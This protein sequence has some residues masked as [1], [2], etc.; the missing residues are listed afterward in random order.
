MFQFVDYVKAYWSDLLFVH[1][2]LSNVLK[3]SSKL[4]SLLFSNIHDFNISIS[5]DDEI[6]IVLISTS[7]DRALTLFI[8]GLRDSKMFITSG[9]LTD[10]YVL[11]IAFTL[12]IQGDEV[13]T[14]YILDEICDKLHE[15][16]SNEDREIEVRIKDRLKKLKIGNII[17]YGDK[18]FHFKTIKN[19]INFLKVFVNNYKL[20]DVLDSEVYEIEKIIKSIYNV[21]IKKCESDLNIPKDICAIIRIPSKEEYYKM[22][23]LPSIFV[24]SFY[25]N[26]MNT[27]FEFRTFIYYSNITNTIDLI[28]EIPKTY[29]SYKLLLTKA[30]IQNRDIIKKTIVKLWKTYAITQKIITL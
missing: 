24:F 26:Y 29:E 9:L 21:N 28:I 12:D 27:Y 4:W 10:D 18:H 14:T 11:P 1:Y 30:L 2:V 13:N 15:L 23:I 3:S 20:I 5:L 19:I 8:K 25:S 6:E 16:L 7:I 22:F 17:K